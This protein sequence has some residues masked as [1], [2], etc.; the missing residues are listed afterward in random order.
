[1]KFQGGASCHE[2]PSMGQGGGIALVSRIGEDACPLTINEQRSRFRKYFDP[3]EEGAFDSFGSAGGQYNPYQEKT[4]YYADE[5]AGCQVFHVCHDVLVSS[6]LC[7]IGSIFS[8][9]LL[10]CDWWTKVDCSSSGKYVD[11]NRNSYQQDDDE[12]I[13]N[14]YAMISLRSGTD[15][16][17]DGLVDPDR[18][19][20]IVDYQRA[21]LSD[22]SP[23]VD[24]P[25]TGN[26]LRTNFEEPHRAPLPPSPRDFLLP[27]RHVN[28][29]PGR[30]EKLYGVS[31][32]DDDR[33]SRP[34]EDSPIIRVQKIGD[35]GYEGRRKGVSLQDANHHRTIGTNDGGGEGRFTNRQ[36]QPSYA[37]TVPTVTTTTRRFYSPTVPT[38]FRPLHSTLAYNTLDQVID[39]SDYYFSGG[40][41]TGFVTPSPPVGPRAEEDGRRIV[42]TSRKATKKARDEDYEYEEEGRRFRVR[43]V[44]L[45]PRARN[46]SGERWGGGLE[47]DFE[48]R[49]SIG[50]GQ[51]LR[52]SLQRDLGPSPG[53]VE[54][55]NGE[56][57]FLAAYGQERGGSH[58]SSPQ[59]IP[60]RWSSRAL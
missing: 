39:S 32:Q 44:D 10:T 11:V 2:E 30:Q 5:V 37:P 53:S 16:T 4:G 54:G 28:E 20:S 56:G 1:M 48:T 33:S 12:M 27:Y 45:E 47:D 41:G 7:P 9:K 51:A 34:Y 58:Q 57:W 29:K 3:E 60:L 59:P 55:R 19:G 42:E 22:Y 18:T 38:T 25:P 36:F 13:R 50:L 43:V 35:P 23:P 14:A 21:S 40:K 49:G 31:S 52:Q 8:Q 26:D 17:R 15:V 6:F 46:G 24:S